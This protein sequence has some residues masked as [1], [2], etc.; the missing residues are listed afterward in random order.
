MLKS[1]TN[2]HILALA[3]KHRQAGIQFIAYLV[4]VLVGATAYFTL[5]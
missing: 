3:R 4:I 1:I 5:A 2:E